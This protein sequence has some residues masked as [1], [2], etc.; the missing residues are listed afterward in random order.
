[1]ALVIMDAY[2]EQARYR[3]LPG[4]GTVPGG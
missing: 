3:N 1:V 4:A 2:L